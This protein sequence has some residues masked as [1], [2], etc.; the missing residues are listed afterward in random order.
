MIRHISWLAAPIC[1]QWPLFQAI[2][3]GLSIS[4]ALFWR[5]HGENVQM[6][7]MSRQGP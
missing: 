7:K 4:L 6:V 1:E 3:C 5:D 2:I